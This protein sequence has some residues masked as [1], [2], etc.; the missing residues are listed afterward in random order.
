MTRMTGIVV[1]VFGI[2]VFV[3][4]VIIYR[5]GINKSKV[6]DNSTELNKVIEMA[7]ADGV[8]TKNE[9]KIIKQIAIE[10]DLDFDEVIKD[11]EEQMLALKTNSE[12]ELIDYNKK[13]GDDFEK[14]V[15]QKFDTKYFNIIE[16]AGDKYVNGIYADTTPHPDLLLK[17][18]FKGKITEFSVECKWR[19]KLY[20]NGIEIGSKKQL[21]RY[22]DFEKIK[23][24][25]VFIAIGIGGNGS[26]PEQLYIV[27]L[28]NLNSNFI[29]IK[30]LKKYQKMV[31]KP[32]F[33][34]DETNQFMF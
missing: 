1:M 21:E 11:A 23:K 5:S 18:S 19:Q 4:G 32:L 28:Q 30:D 29:H 15:V 34:N 33:F 10:K 14:F 20:M 24:I 22:R 7:I 27:P 16:W 3:V 2:L 13:N 26:N 8:L 25:P 12:T 31:N 17:F 6:V 9:R